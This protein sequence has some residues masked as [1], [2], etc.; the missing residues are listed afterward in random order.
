M[1]LLVTD[2][3]VCTCVR[4][5]IHVTVEIFPGR[6][7][8]SDI[9]RGCHFKALFCLTHGAGKIRNET[10]IYIYVYTYIN[11]YIYAYMYIYMYIYIYIYI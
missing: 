5:R 6:L 3:S 1:T 9:T 8:H 11:I 2:M 4:I 10:Y 7:K